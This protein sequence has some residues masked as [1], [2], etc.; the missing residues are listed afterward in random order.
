MK[1]L[2][3]LLIATTN[4][5]K[6]DEFAN[7]L[8]GL[9]LKLR[10]LS[11]FADSPEVLETGTTFE[12]NANLKAAAYAAETN[13]WTLADDS[14]LEVAALG[15]APGVFSARYGGAALSDAERSAKLL[16]ELEKTKNKERRA[17]FVSVISLANPA[18]AIQIS[19]NGVCDGVI[20]LKSLGKNGFGYDSVF[21]PDGFKQTFGELDPMIKEKISHRTRATTE[22]MRFLQQ[23]F[24]ISL[25]QAE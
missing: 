9:P 3:E 7:L 8:S 17:R 2:F 10:S 1:D 25:D 15:G 22:I 12:E 6:T 14:G 11:E 16:S 4:K 5:G 24:E 13:L 19:A 20:S 21:I 18:G 23:F